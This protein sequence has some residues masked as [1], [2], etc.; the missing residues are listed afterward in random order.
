MSQNAWA[1][2]L[3]LSSGHLA[4][5][6]NGK[7]PYPDPETRN[8]LMLGLGLEFE[9]LFEV[10]GLLETGEADFEEPPEKLRDGNLWG[11]PAGENVDR[12]AS[13]ETFMSGILQD[14][15]HGFR[16]LRRT[17]GFSLTAALTLFLGVGSATLIFSLVNSVLLQPLPFRDP[18][19]LYL[20]GESN[21]ERNWNLVQISPA[22]FLDVKDRNSVFENVAAYNDYLTS[23]TF[24]SNGI[25]HRLQASQVTGDLFSV[26]G[27]VPVEGRLFKDSDSWQGGEAVTILSHS[28]WE[29][30]WG[31]DPSIVG[32]SILLNGQPVRV[33]GVLPSHLEF[34][35]HEAEL[36]L[37]TQW[38]RESLSRT[39]FRRARG[40]R[41]IARLKAGISATAAREELERIG[42]DLAREYPETNRG[43]SFGMTGLHGWMVGDSGE[44]LWMLLAA[45]SLLLLIAS[46]NVANLLLALW[47]GRSGEIAVRVALGAGRNRITQQAIVEALL[48]CLPAGAAAF[49]V[50]WLLTG[51]LRIVGPA[52]L[53]RLSELSMDWRV[54]GLSF[55]LVLVCGLGFG[56]LQARRS[57]SRRLAST[58]YSLGRGGTEISGHH[59]LGRSL[60]VVQVALALLLLGGASLFARSFWNLIRVDPGFVAR[61]GIVF[62]TRLP[63]N[64][65]VDETQI[66]G[67]YDQLLSRLREL[68]GVD[69]ATLTSRVPFFRQRYSSDFAAERW[70]KGRYAVGIRHGEVVPGYFQTMGIPI[71]RGRE[72]SPADR[73]DSRL[74][75]II[76]EGLALEFFPDSDPLGQRVAF[77]SEPAPDSQWWEIVGIAGDV[78]RLDLASAPRPEVYV[79]Y[80]QDW[81][82]GRSMYVV[83][84]S[85]RDASDL[86]QTARQQVIDL[87]PN[88][89]IFEA[90]TLNEIRTASLAERR[91]F[92]LTLL[93]FAMVSCSMS[94]AGVYG[95]LSHYLARRRCELGLRTALGATRR[96]LVRE[97]T[98]GGMKP[99]LLGLGVGVVLTA[100]ATQMVRNLLFQIDPLDP[101]TI[102][103]CV[104]LLSLVSLLSCLIPAYRASRLDPVLS[105]RAD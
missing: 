77:D 44:Y 101:G 91:F 49:L 76:S 71:L 68:P 33:V 105:L 96:D 98:R 62:G 28:V 75:A 14:L 20:I 22:N 83:M 15:R 64:Q 7:R 50:T 51:Y 17:P 100:L 92:L 11:S 47:A 60:I 95:V 30:F 46:T 42:R 3:G 58:L 61:D 102:L 21:P 85:Q 69:S 72:F 43:G 59:L 74:V 88:L 70:E 99:V 65:Y 84:R 4:N 26:L 25:P 19:R 79:P 35:L 57:A 73:S 38:P 23:L 13:K 81:A 29:R 6:V 93:V 97:A 48:L 82:A 41:A 80:A 8:K 36:W 34:P 66:L 55:G 31:E 37:P 67:F 53:P 16:T 9:E 12:I 90:Q 56:I 2:K 52:S 104:V 94:V 87:D 103:A 24:Q 1:R 63:P 45:V 86:I 39:S 89:P 27:V 40:M 18:D 10:E 5:L 32:R 54:L 78:H